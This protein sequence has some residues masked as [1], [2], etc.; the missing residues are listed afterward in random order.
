MSRSRTVRA[1]GC[2]VYRRTEGTI[3]VLVVHRPSYDDWSFPKG[4]RDEGETDYECALRETLEETG[5]EVEPVG[6]LSETSY[7]LASGKNK[8]VRFWYSEVKGGK[9]VKNSEVDAIKWLDIESA[10]EELSYDRDKDLLDEFF[11][12]VN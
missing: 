9:F 12:L 6:E 1:A 4:K 8:K 10:R 2:V 7:K 5:F 3:E 11:T